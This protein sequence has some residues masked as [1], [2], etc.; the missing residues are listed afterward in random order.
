MANE[1]TWL[2]NTPATPKIAIS[3]VVAEPF[4]QC[5]ACSTTLSRGV[6]TIEHEDY[7]ETTHCPSCSAPLREIIPASSLPFG[8]PQLEPATV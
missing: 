1:K 4:K 3:K 2:G 6:T 7:R 8:G 5:T